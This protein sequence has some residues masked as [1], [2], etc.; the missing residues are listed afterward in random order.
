VIC[1]HPGCTGYHTSQTGSR[2]NRRA[3][4]MSDM[5]PVYLEQKRAADA[6]TKRRYRARKAGKDLAV[7]EAVKYDNEVRVTPGCCVAWTVRG[8]HCANPA[9]GLACVEH[10]WDF[11]AVAK[12]TARTTRL[13]AEDIEYLDTLSGAERTRERKRLTSKRARADPAYHARELERRRAA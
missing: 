2:L 11:D 3:V 13:T 8:G 5:C 10:K 12:T 7:V 1:E 4:P 9:N 6:S